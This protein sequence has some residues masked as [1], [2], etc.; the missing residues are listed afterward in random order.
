MFGQMLRRATNGVILS[1]ILIVTPQW[2][3]AQETAD[4]AA[5]PIPND[6]SN[7]IGDRI[8]FAVNTN[9]TLKG[10]K[11][12]T[13]CVPA[14]TRM[15]VIGKDSEGN[16]LVKIGGPHLMQSLL[17]LGKEQKVLSCD[18][19]AKEID[20]HVAYVVSRADLEQSGLAR[21]GATYGALVV[22]FKWHMQGN[23]DFT[24]SSTLGA[25]LGYRFETANAIGFTLTPIGFMGASNISVPNPNGSGTDQNL[26]GFA[27]GTGLIGTFKGSFQVGVVVGWDHVSR[28]AGYQYNGKPWLAMEIGFPFL[29]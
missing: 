13:I 17:R 21:T 29:Q 24:G 12:N 8:R 10:D 14:L 1:W 2:V 22:P 9:V 20:S 4:K 7:Y 19:P 11:N 6:L 25:Y 27:L 15:S 26:S 28:N 5:I 18:T 23:R 3:W 16:L